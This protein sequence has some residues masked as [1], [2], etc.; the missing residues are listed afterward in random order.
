ME[1]KEV[2]IKKVCPICGGGENGCYD[3]GGKGYFEE[4]INFDK[5]VEKII[6]VKEKWSP[7]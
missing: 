4:W 2:F 5:F 3:C 6:D 7:K 1:I